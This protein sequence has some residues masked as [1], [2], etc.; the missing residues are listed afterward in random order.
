[1]AVHCYGERASAREGIK[2]PFL[3]R[4]QKAAWHHRTSINLE[5]AVRESRACITYTGY[6]WV[7]IDRRGTGGGENC[8]RNEWRERESLTRDSYREKAEAENQ[9]EMAYRRKSEKTEM[10]VLNWVAGNT[11]RDTDFVD[12]RIKGKFKWAVG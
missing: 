11:E 8:Q 7:Y 3:S 4:A 10:S 9:S 1:M 5:R 6:D 12:E 2:V